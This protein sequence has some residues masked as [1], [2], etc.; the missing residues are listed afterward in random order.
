[1]VTN[2]FHINFLINATARAAQTFPLLGGPGGLCKS[3]REEAAMSG[4]RTSERASERARSGWREV[5]EGL[6]R[7][8]EGLGV[9]GEVVFR[10]R[11]EMYSTPLRTETDGQADR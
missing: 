1:M 8:A 4:Q 2:D 5:M 10:D 3:G 9:N 11:G 6:A 7:R